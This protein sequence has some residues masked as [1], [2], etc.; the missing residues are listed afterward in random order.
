MRLTVLALTCLAS[1]GCTRVLRLPR[2]EAP[3]V[4]GQF[5][6]GVNQRTRLLEVEV[7]E[8]KKDAQRSTGLTI[9]SG[10]AKLGGSEKQEQRS[11][12]VVQRG[13]QQVASVECHARQEGVTV[14]LSDFSRHTLSCAG[15]GFALEVQEPRNDAF[16]GSARVGD[17]ALALES[18]DDLEKGVPQYPTGFH[19]T[20]NGRWLGTFEYVNDGKAWLRADLTG[21]ERDAVLAVMVVMQST[22]RWLAK[23]LGANQA[24]AFGL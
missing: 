2:M 15:A 7:P 3:P 9:R 13:G 21:A 19:L 11:T 23:D 4:V 8:V 16:I 5:E 17:V 24:R 22:D 18:T 20:A 12:L 1:L 6:Q 14:N 10:G